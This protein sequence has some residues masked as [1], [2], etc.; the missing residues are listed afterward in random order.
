METI[1]LPIIMQGTA[2]REKSRAKSIG[3][4]PTM[5]AL[6]D[7]HMALVRAARAENDIVVASVFVNPIQF[8]AGEDLERYPRRLSEDIE[9]LEAADT[10]ILFLPEAS[11]IY[12]SGFSTSVCVKGL[13]EKLCGAFRP[14]HFEGVAT[15]VLKLL[16]IVQ[17]ARVYFG[18]KDYQQSLIIR[19]LVK[20]M[21]LPVEVVLCLTLREPD[22]LAISSRNGYLSAE[23][24]KA[25][26]VIYRA[27][28]MG[29]E[30]VKDGLKSPSELGAL[31]R[32]ALATEPL[33]NEIQYIGAYD[34]ET[35]DALETLVKKELLLATAVKIGQTRLIDNLLCNGL[36]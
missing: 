17:P 7:G 10:D 13:S 1:R 4:V 20:D 28:L 5:G 34:P 8:S 24:R 11:N 32:E 26:T 29:A 9:K 15:V 30:A 27:L 23:E 6:H 14:G 35:L 18:L 36:K 19:R 22:G 33:I 25:A 16:N 12:P 31:M 3:F 2:L 21:L